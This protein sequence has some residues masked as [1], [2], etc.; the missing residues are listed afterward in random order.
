MRWF[1]FDG[2]DEETYNKAKNIS[3]KRFYESWILYMFGF[4]KEASN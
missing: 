2:S 4:Q 1:T 3:K